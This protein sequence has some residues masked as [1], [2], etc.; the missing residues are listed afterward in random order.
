MARAVPVPQQVCF[1]P[2]N[3]IGNCNLNGCKADC[4]KKMKSPFGECVSF[5]DGK[6]ICVCRYPVKRDSPCRPSDFLA[7]LKP[8]K[9]L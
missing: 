5:D 2:I 1:Q 3:K 7:S 9:Y 6:K 4:I 8:K